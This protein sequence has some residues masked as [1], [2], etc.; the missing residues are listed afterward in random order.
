[1][2]PN[3]YHNIM[4]KCKKVGPPS[5]FNSPPKRFHVAK[6]QVNNMGVYVGGGTFEY[7]C[8]CVYMCVHM[9]IVCMYIYA[10]V[11]VHACVHM[12]VR[13]CVCAYI[14]VSFL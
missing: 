2:Q 8:A 6:T 12:H 4:L 10:C 5:I 7:V 3:T 13:V 9:R 14:Y 1:M 11:Y